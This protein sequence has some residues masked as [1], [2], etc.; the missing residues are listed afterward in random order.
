M[1]FAVEVY[2]KFLPENQKRSILIKSIDRLID[3]QQHHQYDDDDD[4]LS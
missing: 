2:T 1:N 4:D 3:Q